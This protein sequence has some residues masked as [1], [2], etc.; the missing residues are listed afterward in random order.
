[1]LKCLEIKNVALIDNLNINF[2]QGLNVLSG[3]TGAGKSI[4]IDALNFVIGSK[5]NKSLIKQ[6]QEVMKVTAVFTAPF[7]DYVIKILNEY[8]IEV[9]DDLIISR[10]MTIDGKSD[11][12]VNGSTVTAS[13]L[14][15]IT[16]HLIDIHGQHEH[17]RLLKD[18]YHLQI[19]DSFVKNKELF[20]EYNSNLTK[21]K[22]IQNQIKNLNGSAE[23]QERM[24]DLLNYQILEIE[25]AKLKPG[26]DDDL[27]QR[28]I[29][30]ESSEKIYDSINT[31]INELDS[32]SSLLANIKRAHSLISNIVKFDESLIE[33]SSRLDS[34]KYELVDIIETLKDK[35]ENCTFNQSEFDE[36]DE[37]L[38]KIKI[39]KKKYGATIEDI[40]LFLK[41]AKEDYDD[42]L[43]SKDKLQFLLKQ[44]EQILL[45]LYSQALNI[46]KIRKEIAVNFENDVKN[47]LNDLGMKNSK[48]KVEFCN[49][50]NVDECES[51]FKTSGLDDV[52]FLF[53]A[54]AGQNL[55]P[56]SEIISGGEASRFML[57]LKNILSAVDN[58][59]CMI[60]DEIDTGISG[61]M[62]Y[63]VACKLANIS[64]TCQIMSVSHL[65]QICA[66]ADCNIKISKYVQD[67][68]TNVKATL[69][70][71]KEILEEISR[72]SGGSNDSIVSLNHA[73]ELK[74]RCN[75]YKSKV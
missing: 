29:L 9:E 24:L 16:S 19:I 50:P 60:F 22:D 1:M 32:Q 4:I 12:K 38:D 54:N 35:K 46:S 15:N 67:D 59:S 3:E 34:T 47:Q 48:F 70:N 64:K 42:I 43:N 14:K 26:E 66:M 55:K 18:K 69:L 20:S 41:K 31:A 40:L 21:L 73:Q 53:S 8:D 17:Q 49:L 45:N 71:D 63:K 61:D 58:I 37:R 68:S 13:M 2:F 33:I 72:L 23:N 65:P 10:K 6:G 75:A 5:A 25:N 28:K 30:M 51:L 56:L 7:S 57:A 11:I 44:K 62:G 39:L 74:N 36:I 52:R 27:L